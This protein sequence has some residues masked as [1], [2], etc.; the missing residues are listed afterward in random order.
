MS[1]ITATATEITERVRNEGEKQL[2]RLE[3]LAHPERAR[4]A[5]KRRRVSKLSLVVLIVGVAFAVYRSMRQTSSSDAVPTARER[6]TAGRTDD[7]APVQRLATA[8]L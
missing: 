5:A 3:A 7:A 2:Q 4:V 1:A 8:A 6:D